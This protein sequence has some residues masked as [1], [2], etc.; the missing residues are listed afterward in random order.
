MLGKMAQSLTLTGEN[1]RLALL[2]MV[3]AWNIFY[4]FSNDSWKPSK[5][6]NAIAPN[7]RAHCQLRYI[8]GTKLNQNTSFLR[9]H[10]DEMGF[11]NVK[12]EQP[13]L[14]NQGGFLASRTEISNP[15]FQ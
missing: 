15:W 6:I 12:I 7:S 8:A 9:R 11:S 5:P 13:P 4:R 10:L 14:E 2:R 1:L 3:F